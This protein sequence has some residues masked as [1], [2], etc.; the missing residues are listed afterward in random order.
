M[1]EGA[2]VG[3]KCGVQGVRDVVHDTEQFPQH[4]PVLTPTLTAPVL[5][6]G[7]NQPS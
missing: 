6:P 5:L 1:A 3:L 7:Q 4:P 2:L